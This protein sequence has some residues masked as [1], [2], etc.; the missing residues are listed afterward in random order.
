M[1]KITSL[2]VDPKQKFSLTI[3]GYSALEIRLEFKPQQY[4]WF[5]KATWGTWGIDNERVVFSPNLLWQWKDTLP[6]GIGIW[7]P[8]ILDPFA[9]DAWTTGW[10]FYLLDDTDKATIEAYYVRP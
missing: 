3:P 1:K 2:S 9:V 10:E 6:F 7:G 5:L 4:G 8:D